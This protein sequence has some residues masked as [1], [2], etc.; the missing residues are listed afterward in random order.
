MTNEQEYYRKDNNIH[1]RPKKVTLNSG[2]SIF[3]RREYTNKV[4]GKPKLQLISDGLSQIITADATTTTVRVGNRSKQ[5]SC[6]CAVEAPIIKEDI[7]WIASDKRHK[8]EVTS[9]H[10]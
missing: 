2:V 10:Q 9:A 8:L 1:M 7:L 3:V 5:N 4:D 6:D